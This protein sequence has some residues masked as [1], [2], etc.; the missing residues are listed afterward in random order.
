[1]NLDD[2]VDVTVGD[3]NIAQ[4]E[5]EVAFIDF[6]Y[7]PKRVQYELERMDNDRIYFKAYID[8]ESFER[9]AKEHETRKRTFEL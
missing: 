4:I 1:M 3:M 2:M 7:K 6:L 5:L 8:K 9:G